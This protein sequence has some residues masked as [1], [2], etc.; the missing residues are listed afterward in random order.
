MENNTG[1]KFAFFGIIVL[2]IAIGGFV[3]MQKSKPI[4]NL[5]NETEKTTEKKEIKDIRL[6]KSEDYIYYQ[7]NERVA[8]DV[9]IEFKDI[10]LNFEDKNNIASTLNNET[11]EFKSLL[12]YDETIDSEEYNKVVTA[13]YKT[14]EFYIYEDYI[15]L[16]INYFS[17]DRE[18]LVSFL[19]SKTYVFNKN[20]GDLIT[21][22]E[23]LAK[24]N[25]TVE[26]IKEKVMTF[27]KDKNL[28]VE[29]EELD[30]EGTVNAL[31]E[32]PLFIDKIGRLSISVLVKSNQKDYNE[33]II[34]Y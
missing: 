26:T 18:N 27:V 13:K 20:T 23:L 7:N 17:F 33:I 19:N 11:K 2:T 5:K 15:S 31:N 14:Y 22:D 29:G 32:Y 21:T 1:I 8:N 25:L 6:N 12:K 28:L 10:I 16:L 34:L 3:L 24:N 4:N 30:A 9:D